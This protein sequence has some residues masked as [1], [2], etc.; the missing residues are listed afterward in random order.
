MDTD[1]DADSLWNSQAR[2]KA[3]KEAQQE[4]VDVK[5]TLLQPSWYIQTCHFWRNNALLGS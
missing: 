4:K 3:L 5:G 2:G 1:D